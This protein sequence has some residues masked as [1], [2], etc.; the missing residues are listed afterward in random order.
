MS[1]SGLTQ[2]IRRA[3]VSIPSNIAEG[4][5]RRTR[6]AYIYHLNI[7]LG[8]LAELETQLDACRELRIRQAAMTASWRKLHA[9]AGQLV[10]ALV[11]A[12]ENSLER[13]VSHVH[14][15]ESP[16]PRAPSPAV[17][18]ELHS[19]SAFSF[20]R[21]ATLPEPLVDRAAMLGYPAVALL[22]RDGVYGA[23]RFHKAATAAG[24]K[25][26]IGAELT[27]WLGTGGS[28]TRATGACARGRSESAA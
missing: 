6:Q 14:C 23:P 26:L 21:A 4:H 1:S 12:L 24:L 25:P 19:S 10:M 18:V 20:L 7:A 28:G 11:H 22:D 3:A 16:S 27:L 8:S 9:Q 15:P 5:S 2:Q 17:Y 13:S